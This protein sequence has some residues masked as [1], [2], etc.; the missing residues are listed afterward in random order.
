MTIK[1][2]TEMRGTI[3]SLI[4]LNEERRNKGDMVVSRMAD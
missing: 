2:E 4:D 1:M 3:Q